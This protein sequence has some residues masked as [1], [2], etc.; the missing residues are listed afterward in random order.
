MP[1][2]LECLGIPYMTGSGFCLRFLV[3]SATASGDSHYEGVLCSVPASKEGDVVETGKYPSWDSLN[4][5]S[6]SCRSVLEMQNNIQVLAILF[7]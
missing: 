7:Y 2:D 6:H 5:Q 3:L 4:L 1:S